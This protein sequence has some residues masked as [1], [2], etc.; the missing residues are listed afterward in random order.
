MPSTLPPPKEDSCFISYFHYEYRF[1][2]TFILAKM[3]YSLVRVTRRDKK[4]P[5]LGNKLPNEQLFIW[6]MMILNQTKI[7]N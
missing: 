2:I 3:L 5:L 7:P 1:C 6:K 4:G